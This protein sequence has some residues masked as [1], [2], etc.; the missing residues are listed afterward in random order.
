MVHP[1]LQRELDNNPNAGPRPRYISKHIKLKKPAPEVSPTDQDKKRGLYG[2]LSLQVKTLYSQLTIITN[3]STRKVIQ[4]QIKELKKTR[5]RLQK[6]RQQ[7]KEEDY[8]SQIDS[9]FDNLVRQAEA[10][11]KKE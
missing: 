7:K 3:E 8:R 1:D 10:G 9:M 2:Q 4:E 6:S 11:L 5:R